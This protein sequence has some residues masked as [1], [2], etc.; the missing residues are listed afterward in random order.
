VTGS[1]SA[2]PDGFIVAN[3]VLAV[4]N[5]INAK[6]SGKIPDTSPYGPPYCDVN[7]DD[8]VV[9]QDV[10]DIINYINANP[11]QNEAE[12]TGARQFGSNNLSSEL[13]SLLAFDI[14]EQAVRRR[15]LQ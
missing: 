3:D 2:P 1:T 6:G 9:A 14:A 10:L 13:I 5:F 11:G 7:G 12:A 15:R 8:Q 4:I